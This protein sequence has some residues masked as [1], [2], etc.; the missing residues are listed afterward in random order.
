MA[1]RYVLV[2]IVG[3][4]LIV[5]LQ[6]AGA[7]STV[8]Q[9]YRMLLL[10]QI[11]HGDVEAMTQARQYLNSNHIPVRA[12]A[13]QAIGRI[14]QAD[15]E[16]I[17]DLIEKV[18]TDHSRVATAAAGALG[19]IEI[20]ETADDKTAYQTEVL[21]TLIRALSHK[22][23][24][25]RRYAA[26]SIS[27]Y[28]TRGI[29][30]KRATAA[31]VKCLTDQ[32]MGSMAA[33]ALGDIGATD[34]AGDIAAMLEG[35]PWHFRQEAAVALIQLQPLPIKIQAQLDELIENDAGVREAVKHVL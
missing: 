29:D 16:V 7:F 18:N 32:R 33:R 28:G 13:A 11:A 24:E 5:G 23:S 6:M 30:A 26:H 19:R 14:G 8:S 1:F 9:V 2:T 35:S 17:S 25:V 27:I 21:D 34:A 15:A 10:G 3:I 22:N 4:C 31:L 12:A 20:T